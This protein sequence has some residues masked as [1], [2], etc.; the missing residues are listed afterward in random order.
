MF[1]SATLI[2]S[3]ILSGV[4]SILTRWDN[5][6]EIHYTIQ[7]EALMLDVNGFVSTCN[8]TNFFIVKNGI[9]FTS[10]GHVII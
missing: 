7:D 4:I 9:V 3:P 8:S 2:L 1:K 5:L 6:H 10:T